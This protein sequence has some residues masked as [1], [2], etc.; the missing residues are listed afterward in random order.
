MNN[1]D[2][3]I[4]EMN[5]LAKNNNAKLITQ[6]WAGSKAKYEF[7]KDGENFSIRYDKLQEIGWPK[8]LK[9]FLALSAAHKKDNS[10]LIEELKEFAKS[11]NAKLLDETWHGVEHKYTF[12]SLADENVTFEYSKKNINS[13]NKRKA[14]PNSEQK[15]RKNDALN[16]LKDLA[17]KN[18]CQ[19]ISTEWVNSSHTYEF[20]DGKQ[21]FE[22]KYEYIMKRG[23]PQDLEK[24]IKQSQASQSAYKNRM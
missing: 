21:K 16:K 6:I 1:Y 22:I 18:G 5:D 19:L 17:E 12:Q 8:D 2:D 20:S 7:E 3:K 11:Q 13:L 23:W 10:L 9:K 14:S 24:Y 15:E 4:K